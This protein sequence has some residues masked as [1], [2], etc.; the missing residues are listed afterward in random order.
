MDK[1]DA[2]ALRPSNS[3]DLLAD[4]SKLRYRVAFVRRTLTPHR[5]VYQAMARWDF[6]LIS[7]SDSAAH[8]TLLQDS[9]ERAIEAVENARELLIASIATV[10]L[11]VARRRRW[12]YIRP[13]ECH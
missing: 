9:L 2:Q 13:P 11:V 8:F 4:L 3:R 10:T 1:I 6:H 5:E 7:K 12:I